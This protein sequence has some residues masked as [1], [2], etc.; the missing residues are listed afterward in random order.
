MLLLLLNW[1][2]GGCLVVVRVVVV[3]ILVGSV[4]EEPRDEFGARAR[5]RFA[6]FDVRGLVVVVVVVRCILHG[7]EV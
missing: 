4:S 1:V 2:V 5:R 6:T 3:C 7:D